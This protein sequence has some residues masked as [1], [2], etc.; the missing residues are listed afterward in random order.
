[1]T[2]QQQQ[3]QQQF[4][5]E[6]EEFLSRMWRNIVHEEERLNYW[7]GYRCSNCQTTFAGENAWLSHRCKGIE[8]E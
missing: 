6:H 7:G 8:G 5:K 4:A 2:Q 3:Q 1:M